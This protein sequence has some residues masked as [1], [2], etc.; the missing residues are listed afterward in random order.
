[1][2]SMNLSEAEADYFKRFARWKIIVILLTLALILTIAFAVTIGPMQIPP[3]DVY[4]IIIKNIPF[5]GDLVR[6]GSS[7]I[8]EVVVLQVRLPRVLAAAIVGIAL[9][10][11]GV[12]LQG[13]F[14]NPMADPYLIGI[15]A[16]ASLGASLAIAFG[17]GLSFFGLIYSIPLMAFVFAIGTVI[18]V[19][20][21]AR[22]GQGAQMLTLLLVGIAVNSFLLAIM[23]IVRIV[24]G[25]AI[26]AIMAWILG[27]LVASNWSYVEIALPFVVIGV[28]LIYV[29]AKDLNIILLGEEQAHHLGVNTERLKQI[30]LAS[31]T[32]ITA[33]AVSISGTIGFI[34]LII[35]HIVRISV[36]SD[37]RVL[38]PASALMGAVMLVLCDI[39][40]R[41]IL[42]PAE[43]PV[44]IFTS[45]LGCPFF[46]YLLKK[47]R[48]Q[49]SL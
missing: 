6:G 12:V 24:S 22:T 38:I 26:H 44:G 35:R 16:G 49:T 20:S 15:S 47:N 3:L 48:R 39:M 36:G 4:K 11:A 9:A 46:I 27:S 33:A 41:T 21:V 13:L 7:S 10:V 23:A 2:T 43:L 5:I 1:M 37:N 31:A 17:I 19:Y 18:L 25:D 34:G 45:V 28:A 29:F 32:L 8:E 30:L 14:R 42:A 40:A